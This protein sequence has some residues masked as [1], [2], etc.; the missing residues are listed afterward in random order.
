MSAFVQL[1]GDNIMFNV[2]ELSAKSPGVLIF[3]FFFFWRG[4][5]F[6]LKKPVFDCDI[7]YSSTLPSSCQ[8]KNRR[9]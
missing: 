9:L 7:L 3:F 6:V 1:Q 5:L 4:L 8:E 2:C